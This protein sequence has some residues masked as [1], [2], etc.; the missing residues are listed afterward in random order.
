MIL[1]VILSNLALLIALYNWLNTLM[2]AKHNHHSLRVHK[3]SQLF[4]IDGVAAFANAD[5]EIVGGLQER[6]IE[7]FAHM[8]G[9][10]HLI[11]PVQSVGLHRLALSHDLS[12]EVFALCFQT[13]FREFQSYARVRLQ[14]VV[15]F[16]VLSYF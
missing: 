5:P 7:N 9:S 4:N 12:R 15:Y 8:V 2:S 14:Q 16:A 1:K 3:F 10:P 13:G 6:L 11:A